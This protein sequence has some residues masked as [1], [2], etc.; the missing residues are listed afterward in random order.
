M[1]GSF[2]GGG[3]APLRGAGANATDE[4][5]DATKQAAPGA[6][7]GTGAP[8]T[9]PPAGPLAGLTGT[10]QANPSSTNFWGTGSGT[11]PTSD[12]G[13]T[14][15]NLSTTGR[16][17]AATLQAGQQ[18]Q[19]SQNQFE[20][21][22]G[23]GQS[24][25]DTQM[26][27]ALSA[28]MP[29]FNA[30]LQGLQESNQKRGISNGDLGTSYEGDLASAFQQNFANAAAQ[31]SMNL[32]GTQLGAA[33]KQQQF[34]TENYEGGLGNAQQIAQANKNKKN[35]AMSSIFGTLGAVGGTALAG[36]GG[37]AAGGAIGSSLGSMWS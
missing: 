37:G 33:Q 6:S 11:A 31:Q 8:A 13:S 26:A 10:S 32:Y 25:L 4:A 12:N 23:G 7:P 15:K 35:A 24:A 27:G 29:S 19:Q 36:P 30:D 20:A 22:M 9:P 18:E 1:P 34:E 28:A 17:S 2:F 14:Q 16:E 21:L 3:G 5:D